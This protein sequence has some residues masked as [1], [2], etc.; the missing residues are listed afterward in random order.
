MDKC[1]GQADNGTQVCGYRERC[2]RY[3][4][5]DKSAQYKPFYIAGDDCPKYESLTPYGI[6]P[7]S[8]QS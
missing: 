7:D 8:K 6:S 4:I 3:V 5:E 1:K 2:A